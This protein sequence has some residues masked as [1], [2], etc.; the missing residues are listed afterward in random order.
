MTFQYKIC[1]CSL[2]MSIKL[3]A[4]ATIMSGINEVEFIDGMRQYKSMLKVKLQ[5][6][7]A[8][9]RPAHL[10]IQHLIPVPT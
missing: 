3:I 7:Y 1:F 5:V 4:E 6:G 10:T 2:I 8:T 9:H